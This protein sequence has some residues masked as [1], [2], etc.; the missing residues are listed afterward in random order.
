[1]ILESL[2]PSKEGLWKM[3][4][5]PLLEPINGCTKAASGL[6]F[7][8]GAARVRASL[9]SEFGLLRTQTEDDSESEYLL[10][11][12]LHRL[13]LESFANEGS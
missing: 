10:K 8:I 7:L 1:M 5:S 11:H 6:T 3:V 9:P 4:T 12:C 13:G 2:I